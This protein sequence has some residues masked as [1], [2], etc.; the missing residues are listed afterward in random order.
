MHFVISEVGLVCPFCE[1]DLHFMRSWRFEAYICSDNRLNCRRLRKAWRFVILLTSQCLQTVQSTWN[2]RFDIF[3]QVCAE[4]FL[5]GFVWTMLTS[6]P[7]TV[8]YINV[9]YQGV[10]HTFFLSRFE[11]GKTPTISGLHFVRSF[12]IRSSIENIITTY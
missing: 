8:V 11:K 1:F 4:Y 2:V 10:W 9:A 6:Q 7:P 12:R 5:H 3:F